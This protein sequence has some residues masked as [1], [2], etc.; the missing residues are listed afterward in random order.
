MI[1]LI[2][3]VALAAAGAAIPQAPASAQG[4]L[5]AA[6]AMQIM[7]G[8]YRAA[9]PS[10]EWVQAA[11][12]FAAAQL[13]VEVQEIETAQRQTVQGAN[14][15]IEFSTTEGARYRVVVY[16][17]LRGDMQLTSSEELEA[18]SQ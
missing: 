18:V 16:Q 13:G 10:D 8:G 1:V 9:D 12:Q 4:S 15:R 6:S 14:Y 3:A 7:V 17:P 11:A 2:E 5:V